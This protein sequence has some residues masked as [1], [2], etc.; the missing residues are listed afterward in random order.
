MWK[1]WRLRQLHKLM[2]GQGERLTKFDWK[3]PGLQFRFSWIIFKYP[4]LETYL[5]LEVSRRIV[6][7]VDSN[8]YKVGIFVYAHK[9][10]GRCITKL[11]NKVI[12]R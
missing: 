8:V 12:N 11:L 1:A 6:T 10:E 9:K 2:A 5:K 3:V 4:Y 7:S